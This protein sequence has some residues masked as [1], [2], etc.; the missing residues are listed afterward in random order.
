MGEEAQRTGD[1]TRERQRVLLL[2]AGALLVLAPA[3]PLALGH[4]SWRPLAVRVAWALFIA[5]TA[6]SLRGADPKRVRDMM[7]ALAVLSSALCTAL[8]AL[9]GGIASSLFHVML[10]LPVVVALVIQDQ[11]GA[12]VASGVTLLGGGVGILIASGANLHAISQ[13][14]GQAVVFTLVAAYASASYG[15]LHAREASLRRAGAE[16]VARARA[17]EA[18]IAARDE[19]LAI[20]AHELR[21]PLT[22]LLLQIEAMERS[23][24]TGSGPVSDRVGI[25]GLGRQ[26]RRLSGLIDGM[27]DVTRLTAG[28]LE[29][30]F[31]RVDLAVLVRDVAQRFRADA[32]ASKC[33]MQVD[34]PEP[35]V[36]TWD[37]ARLDQVLTNLLGNAVKYGA[38]GG[39]EIEGRGD[40]AAVR[41]T[42]RDHGIG[43]SAADQ[44][45]IFQRFERAS[46]QRQHPGLGLGLWIS[47]ELCKAMGGQI[48]VASAL[49]AGAA[50]T[51]TLPRRSPQANA[52]QQVRLP[53]VTPFSQTTIKPPRR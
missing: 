15:K 31:E 22:S 10:A 21:T 23:L 49:G 6:G 7:L 36:G 5:L 27:L 52:A 33:T 42:V 25:V 3:D 32:V 39:I 19:F 12:T 43:I 45:R 24:T 11:P 14:G 30:V 35:L 13:W 20:A 46:G 47:S 26:A 28:R 8:A 17:S 41:I 16:A 53:M 37:E 50:F 51:V 38:G 34:L 18:A 40:A 2:C 4:F 44:Q 48:S 9:T 29:L 1:G